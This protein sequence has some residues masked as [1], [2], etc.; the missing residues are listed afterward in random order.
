MSVPLIPFFRL[1]TRDPAGAP[2]GELRSEDLSRLK[3]NT[4]LALYNQLA[5]TELQILAL[6]P[7]LGQ[8]MTRQRHAPEIPRPAAATLSICP[9]SHNN[10]LSP[11]AC[12]NTCWR[13]QTSADASHKPE[14]FSSVSW[15]LASNQSSTS[16]TKIPPKSFQTDLFLYSQRALQ[17]SIHCN[18]TLSPHLFIFVFFF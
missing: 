3:K 16:T 7:H 12:S 18:Y 11:Q 15:E 5:V 4:S 10:V 17:I 9:A 2:V 6:F 1:G 14:G 13:G 8:C